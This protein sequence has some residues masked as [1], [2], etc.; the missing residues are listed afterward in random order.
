VTQL[1][2][3]GGRGEISIDIVV[4]NY[5]YCRFVGDAVDSALA[6]THPWVKVIVVDDGSTDAS[7]DV[8]AQYEGRVELVLKANGGQASALNAGFAR[9]TGDA[10]IFLDADDVLDPNVASLVATSFAEDER[11]VK[12][13][14][15]MEVIDEVGNRT[16]VVKPAPHLPLPQGDVTRAELAFPF[17]LVWL[18][19]SGNA[20]RTDALRRIVPIPEPDF[21]ACPDWYL[22]HLTPLLGRVVSL[23]EVGAFYR[24]HGANS[25]EQ[26]E[27]R[28]DLT[29]VRQTIAYAAVTAQALGKLADELAL[30]GPPG[31]VLS[32]SD[33]ANR[34]LS[35]KLDPARHPNRTD[36]VWPLAVAGTRSAARRF[37][38]SIS[39]KVLYVAWFMGTAAAPRALAR[40]LGELL[41]FP[42]RRK[43]LNRMLRRF[44]REHIPSERSN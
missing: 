7:R 26:A 31:P 32:V 38:V 27:P 14:Y 43:H 36:R 30:E 21:G 13:Q 28:L 9:S 6:Q 34:L 11:V 41:L 17:D 18:A 19:T 22:V 29:H 39:M 4:N 3:A 16:G 44:H 25:Y 37:D 1:P 40:P 23:T 20:F 10:V 33:L 15:R 5:N 8:L 35:R 24:V 12:V 42:E 2:R